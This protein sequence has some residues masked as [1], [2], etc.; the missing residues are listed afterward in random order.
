[1]PVLLDQ[2][3]QTLSDSGLMTK[4]EVQ[5]LLGN[6]SEDDKPKNGEEMARLLFRQGK[7]TKFQTQ[8]VYKGKAKGLI[9]GD[10]VLLDQIGEGGMGQ[11]FRARHRRMKRIVA[12]KVL[13]AELTKS[14]QALDRFQQ[15]VEVAARLVHTNVVTA[16]DAG[17][18]K[19]THFLVMEYVDGQD[20]EAVVAERGRLPVA[21]A[22][23]YVLQT[24]RGL[25]YAHSQGVVHRDIKPA[26]LLLDK[27]GRV[28]ILDMGWPALIRRR[29][30][31]M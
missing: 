28:K 25:E 19:K 16:F 3:V 2:F 11:V 4:Q 1:M 26:N 8:S 31:T 7:L 24:A 22:L 18:T 21:D 12:L 30:I 10:Y 29:G 17:E 9:L 13:P 23:D 5:Q 27:N 6:L 15:E 20:L 14:D